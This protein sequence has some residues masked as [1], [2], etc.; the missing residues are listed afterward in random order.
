MSHRD[1][2]KIK[3]ASFLEHGVHGYNEHISVTAE[4]DNLC[5]ELCLTK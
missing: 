3:V 4:D 5:Y 2:Q 1:I